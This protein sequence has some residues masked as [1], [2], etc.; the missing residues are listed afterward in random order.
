MHPHAAGTER[1]R[2]SGP[3]HQHRPVHGARVA[4]QWQASA[5]EQCKPEG[6]GMMKAICCLTIA[7]IAVCAG[8]DPGGTRR[9]ELPPRKVIV[10]SA[11]QQ[12]WVEYP[13][14]DKRLDEL[15]GLIDR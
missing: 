3:V 11:M 13:G 9:S 1:A 7:A 8:D 12:F 6:G 2:R 14:L 4:S 5:V 10:G 15:S